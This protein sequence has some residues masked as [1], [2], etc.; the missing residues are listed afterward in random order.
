MITTVTKRISSEVVKLKT[1]QLLQMAGRA[2]RRGK[3]TEGTVVVMRNR[4]EDVRMS[5]KILTSPTD[6]IKSHFKTSYGLCV[7]LLE[8]KSLEECRALIERGFG[9]YLMQQRISKKQ[10]E[11]VNQDVENHRSLLQ[12]YTLAGARDYLKLLRRYEKEKKNYDF[13]VGKMLKSEYE[14]VQAIV[15]Y[16]PTGIGIQLQNDDAGFFLGEVKWRSKTKFDGYAV[17]K[18]DGQIL[19]ARKEH[20]RGFADTEDCLSAKTSQALLGLITLCTEWEEIEVEHCQ[21]PLLS[22]F[23]PVNEVYNDVKMQ[24][25]LDDI[26]NKDPFLSAAQSPG[27]ILKQKTLLKDIEEQLKNHPIRAIEGEGERVIEALRY[28]STLKDPIAFVNEKKKNTDSAS[29]SDVFAWKKFQSVHQILQK[30]E[31]LVGTNATDLGQMVMNSN[32]CNSG[33]RFYKLSNIGRF[34]FKR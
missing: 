4:F 28:A 11:R 22:G 30:F 19:V 5:H 33:N 9:A 17:I 26:A 12:K 18:P 16:M 34:T 3:D 7:K 2:G 15:E 20:I 10:V 27:S 21:T 6:G 24:R 8:T 23:Y 32:S 25:A 31:A 29:G 14:L 1:S 13:I